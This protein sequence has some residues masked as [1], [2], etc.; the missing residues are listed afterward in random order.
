MGSTKI[1]INGIIASTIIGCYEYE[2][3]NIQDLIIDVQAQLYR[4]NWIIQDEL[5]TTVDYVKLIDHIKAIVPSTNCY[6]LETLAQRLADELLEYSSLIEQISV[7]LTK[8]A[9][10]GGMAQEIK[11]NYVKKRQFKIALALGSNWEFLP[12]QQIIT[13]IEILGEYINDIKIGGLYETKP[14]GYLEQ[15]N[16]YNT[17]IIGYTS[18][19]PEDLFSKIKSIEKLMGKAE[20]IRN[21]PRIIDID[22]ILFAGLVYTHN[23]LTIPHKRAYLRDFVLLPLA[24]IAGDWVYPTLNKTINQL[25]L[26]LP[27]S[28]SILRKIEF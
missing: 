16:F 3:D 1:Q 25:V 17:A 19:K 2:R 24:D 15:R 10:C 23:F 4:H 6:L 7:T 5:D 28:N 18:L 8:P 26:D 21:G 20:I 13:A 12:Q 11:V 22:L 27:E 14:V 9:I